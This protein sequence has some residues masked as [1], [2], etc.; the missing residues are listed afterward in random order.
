MFSRMSK[1]EVSTSIDG[2]KTEKLSLSKKECIHTD[3]IGSI[4]SVPNSKGTKLNK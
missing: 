3:P 1:S 2:I 4:R